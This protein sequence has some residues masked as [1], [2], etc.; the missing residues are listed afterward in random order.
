M[1]ALVCA[2]IAL[3]TCLEAASAAPTVGYNIGWSTCGP[4]EGTDQNFS[5]DSNAGSHVLFITFAPPAGV[6]HL[7]GVLADIKLTQ[8]S[9]ADLGD[10]WALN[11]GECRDGSLSAL[12]GPGSGSAC[13]DPWVGVTSQAASG[14]TPS[15]FG[16]ERL[17]GANALTLSPNGVSVQPDIEYC[18]VRLVLD[19]AHTDTCDGCMLPV[20]ISVTRFRLVQT[21]GYPEYEL[22]FALRQGTVTWQGGS[23]PVQ[24]PSWSRL[25]RMYR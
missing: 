19:N 15:S 8:A 18:S 16:Y 17:L 25:K 5:C 12:A 23:T 6:D 7:Q 1:R 24:S 20:D 9:L 4:T 13:A 21:N 14:W 11:S 3:S 22:G 10:W 2:L